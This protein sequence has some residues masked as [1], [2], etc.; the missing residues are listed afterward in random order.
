MKNANIESSNICL[1]ELMIKGDFY[2]PQ[3][4][5]LHTKTF[6]VSNNNYWWALS[7]SKEIPSLAWPLLT[8]RSILLCINIDDNVVLITFIPSTTLHVIKRQDTSK[9][10][11]DPIYILKIC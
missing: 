5:L 1:E 3:K 10:L 2:S 9:N 11:S 8:Q 6:P 4:Y 7:Y